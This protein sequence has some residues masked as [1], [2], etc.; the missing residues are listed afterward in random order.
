MTSNYAIEIVVGV[1]GGITSTLSPNLLGN[2]REPWCQTVSDPAVVSQ[3]N[4]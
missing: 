2:Y 3:H 4:R 1:G